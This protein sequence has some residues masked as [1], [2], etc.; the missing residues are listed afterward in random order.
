MSFESQHCVRIK[1]V[2]PGYGD[3]HDAIY[4]TDAEYLASSPQQIE[5]AIQQRVNNWTAS[6]EAARLLPRPTDAEV[7]AAR[8]KE[9]LD[10]LTS[11]D[12]AMASVLDTLVTSFKV[13]PKDRDELRNGL[14]Q[15]MLVPQPIAPIDQPRPVLPVPA[16]R[17]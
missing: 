1:R 5:A 12:P 10:Q 7:H 2:V 11:D 14:K 9:M 13:P 17:N 4:F 8:A 3:Y 6:I 15:S 16:G